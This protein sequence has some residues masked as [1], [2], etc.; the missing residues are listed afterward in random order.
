[1]TQ[2]PQV[3]VD[4]SSDEE[5]PKTISTASEK[6]LTPQDE[7]RAEA[8]KDTVEQQKSKEIQEKLD[9]LQKKVDKD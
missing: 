1:M 9:D 4:T 3:I 7:G 6:P 2:G 8:I 5:A